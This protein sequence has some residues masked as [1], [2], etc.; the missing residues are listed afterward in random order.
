MEIYRYLFAPVLLAVALSSGHHQ[1]RPVRP[2]E[3][4]AVQVVAPLR[5]V[6]E[7]PAPIHPAAPVARPA[8]P[9]AAAAR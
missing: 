1:K 6:A 7:R 4:P 5:P 9:R 2:Q 8:S 3:P